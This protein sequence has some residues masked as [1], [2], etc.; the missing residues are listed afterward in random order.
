MEKL[1]KHFT[2]NIRVIVNWIMV[3]VKIQCCIKLSMM[4]RSRWKLYLHR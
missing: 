3:L 2:T 4:W 1:F